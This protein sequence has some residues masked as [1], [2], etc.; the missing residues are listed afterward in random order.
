PLEYK[1]KVPTYNTLKYNPLHE[2]I[3]FLTMPIPDLTQEISRK[4]WPEDG[5]SFFREVIDAYGHE[6]CVGD[7]ALVSHADTGVVTIV[8]NDDKEGLE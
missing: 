2:Y 5:N 4:I 6:K 3:S 8:Y 1:E 7:E